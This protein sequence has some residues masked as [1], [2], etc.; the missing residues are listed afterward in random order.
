MAK[1]FIDVTVNTQKEAMTNQDGS[2]LTLTGQVR[3]LFE[4]SA[5]KADILIALQ[6][7]KDRITEILP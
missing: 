4:D 6:R 2:A 1:R 7:I 3:V 5:T